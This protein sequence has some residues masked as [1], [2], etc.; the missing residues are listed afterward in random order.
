MNKEYLKADGIDI[1]YMWDESKNRS[2]R[3][4]VDGNIDYLFQFQ[5]VRLV[6]DVERIE[7]FS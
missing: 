2:I 5:K 4:S 1:L 3:V 7:T 6:A